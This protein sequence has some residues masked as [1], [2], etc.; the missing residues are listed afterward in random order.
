MSNDN[1]SI[2]EFDFNLICEYFSNIE[3]QGLDSPVITIKTLS[4]NIVLLIIFNKF[5][6]SNLN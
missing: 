6:F 5:D 1:T 3:K 2:H 4:F